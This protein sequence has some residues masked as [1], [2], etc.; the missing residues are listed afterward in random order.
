MHSIA[1][2][3]GNPREPHHTGLHRFTVDGSYDPHEMT[4]RNTP[5]RPTVLL[6]HE[7]PDGTSHVDWM[8]APDDTDGRELLVT[9]RVAGRVDELAAGGQLSA[10]RIDDHRRA[11]LTYEGPVSN[12]RGTVRRLAAGVVVSWKRDQDRWH[13]EIEWSDPAGGIR[14]QTLS[15]SR[16]LP[17]DEWAIEAVRTDRT[18]SVVDGAGG[19]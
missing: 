5:G 8:I 18:T 2:R 4:A 12:A 14:R 10:R 11:Y 17:G 15:V 9:F 1:L 6:L 3:D 7:L 13:M 19:V 16:H